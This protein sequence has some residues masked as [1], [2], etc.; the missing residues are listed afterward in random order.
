MTQDILI[1]DVLIMV[2]LMF[3]FART[4]NIFW[5][6]PAWFRIPTPT[7]DTLAMFSSPEDFFSPDLPGHLAHQ[8]EAL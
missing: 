6:T 4:L 5:A 1:S 8:L 3:S 7:M 2:M